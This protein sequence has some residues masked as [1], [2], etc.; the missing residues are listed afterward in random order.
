MA[1]KDTIDLLKSL[2]NQIDPLTIL[3]NLIFPSNSDYD[4][5][6]KIR[7]YID[8]II[9]YFPIYKLNSFYS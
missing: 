6:V 8:V 5:E 1:P 3:P 7:F 4:I 9:H 2:G